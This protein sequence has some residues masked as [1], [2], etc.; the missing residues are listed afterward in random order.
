MA[1][2]LKKI[3]A[4]TRWH[5]KYHRKIAA[6]LMAFF[7]FVAVTGLLLGWKKTPGGWLPAG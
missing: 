3:A 6:V 2:H 1:Q 5:R 4:K 7:L